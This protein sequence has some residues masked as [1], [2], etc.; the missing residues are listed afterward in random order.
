MLYWPWKRG[1]R[2]E[3]QVED[4]IAS[5]RDFHVHRMEWNGMEGWNGWARGR[6]G[7]V[8]TRKVRNRKDLYPVDGSHLFASH[9]KRQNHKCLKG[10]WEDAKELQSCGSFEAKCSE[11]QRICM[12]IRLDGAQSLHWNHT[13]Q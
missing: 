10:L 3:R 8:G 9:S 1:K 4:I 13:S 2:G 5:R 12:H 11:F 6:L 7:V